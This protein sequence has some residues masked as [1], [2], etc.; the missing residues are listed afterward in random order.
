MCIIDDS[1]KKI[2]CWVH[3]YEPELDEIVR[4][5]SE[6]RLNVYAY[7]YIFIYQYMHI[8]TYRYINIFKLKNVSHVYAQI[9]LVV[10][11]M[12]LYSLFT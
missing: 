6:S 8:L 4:P 10:A 5:L 7:I 2:M 3:Q 9:A 11:V 12:W 1:H